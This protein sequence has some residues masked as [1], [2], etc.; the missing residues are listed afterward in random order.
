MA[1]LNP[2]K[3]DKLDLGWMD[4]AALIAVLLCVGVG[5]YHGTQSLARLH[6]PMNYILPLVVAIVAGGMV[7][8]IWHWL[9]R[10]VPVMKPP[11]N[12]VGIAFGLLVTVVSVFTIAIFLVSALIGDRAI[13]DHLAH[14]LNEYEDALDRAHAN[15]RLEEELI[16]KL[17]ESRAAAE[18]LAEGEASRGGCGPRCR[19]LR[20]ALE[21]FTTAA[22]LGRENQK[23]GEE[24]YRKTQEALAR[25][26]ER[27]NG[28]LSPQEASSIFNNAKTAVTL[29]VTELENLSITQL[30]FNVG[31]ISIGTEGRYEIE[32]LTEG[33][34]ETAEA[35][36]D[37]REAVNVPNF[38][39]INQYE[40]V[41]RDIGKYLLL[42][43]FA[44][45]LEVFPLLLLV[46][47]VI[48]VW[49]RGWPTEQA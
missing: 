10:Y 17:N 8:A 36:A 35:I 11:F 22:A 9:L 5:V 29:A 20:G 39:V 21:G 30:S 18:G 33:V 14:G 23:D 49:S 2:D 6:G 41:T 19:S 28:N 3:L 24:I 27:I 12:L 4:H 32:R 31:A 34:R 44:V 43:V 38:T 42:W 26:R 46:A 40:A 16:T 37:S 1:S 15:L 7:F 45:L 13:R 47:K 48:T 25:A